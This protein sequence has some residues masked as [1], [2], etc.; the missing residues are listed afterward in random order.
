MKRIKHMKETRSVLHELHV[1]HG[2]SFFR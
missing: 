2:E 1:L